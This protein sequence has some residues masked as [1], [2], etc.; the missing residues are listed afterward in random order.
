VPQM[1]KRL[2][3]LADRDQPPRRVPRKRGRPLSARRILDPDGSG[4]LLPCGANSVLRARKG[5]N[6]SGF[7][8]G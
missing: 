1:R 6:E 7:G 3:I 4:T 8:L 5:I 2:F